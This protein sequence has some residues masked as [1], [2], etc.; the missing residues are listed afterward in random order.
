MSGIGPHAD[1]PF[2]P[3]TETTR[4]LE[5]GP[6]AISDDLELATLIVQVG[7][8]GNALASQIRATKYAK[9]SPRAVLMRDVGCTLVGAAAVTF[10][11]I[12][13][14]RSG[15]ARLRPLAL[16][17]GGDP[18]LLERVGKL[19]AG[20][21]P[22]SDLMDRARNQLGFHWDAAVISPALAEFAR[23][24]RLV[25]M[26]SADDDDFVH[27][28]SSEVMAHALFP[29]AMGQNDLSVLD[30]LV[31]EA[32]RDLKDA[33]TIIVEFSVAA[34]FGFLAVKGGEKRERGID[35]QNS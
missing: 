14:V 35:G 25:W 16:D 1:P 9:Q 21:H 3:M 12:R 33:M 32:M 22:A 11:A 34:T 7:M 17:G 19:C 8:A 6:S 2:E 31:H 23:N 10:E 4:W 18:S 5:S 26:E 24:E 20:K 29:T 28:L 15:L 30:Q 27:R 13:V